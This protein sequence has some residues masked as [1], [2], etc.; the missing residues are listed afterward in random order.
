MYKVNMQGCKP[1]YYNTQE[2]ALKTYNYIW[3]MV[4]HNVSIQRVTYKRLLKD[5]Y[6]RG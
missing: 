6:K 1:S 5:M 2:K 4:T 3:F